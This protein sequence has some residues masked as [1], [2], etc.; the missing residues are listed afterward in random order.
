MNHSVREVLQ[1]SPRNLTYMDSRVLNW[2][3]ERMTYY[4][5]AFAFESLNKYS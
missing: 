4:A 3:Q 2:P 5:E 1:R